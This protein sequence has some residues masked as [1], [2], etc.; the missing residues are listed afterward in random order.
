MCAFNPNPCCLDAYWSQGAFQCALAIYHFPNGFHSSTLRAVLKLINHTDNYHEIAWCKY[1]HGSRAIQ[2]SQTAHEPSQVCTNDWS[3]LEHTTGH[4]KSCPVDGLFSLLVKHH[5][6]SEMP[7]FFLQRSQPS[8]CS[9][10]FRESLLTSKYNLINVSGTAK[11]SG[12]MK[13]GQNRKEQT[14]NTWVSAH[15]QEIPFSLVMRVFWHASVKNLGRC[16]FWY[17]QGVYTHRV[18]DNGRRRKEWY[19]TNQ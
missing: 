19:T 15:I 5:L 4:D 7:L 17:S 16:T 9:P 8:A 1:D 13:Q 12:T 18:S 11:C 3:G 2:W 14:S 10:T 6:Q